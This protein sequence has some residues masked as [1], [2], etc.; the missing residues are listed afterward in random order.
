DAVFAGVK[1][2]KWNPGKEYTI[3]TF[4]ID[5]EEDFKL[6]ADTK[7]TLMKK[8][9]RRN[10]EQGWHF[11]TGKEKAIRTLA[12][13]VGFNYEKIEATGEYA[14]SA[15]IMFLSPDGVITRYLYGISFNENNIR[16]AL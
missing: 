2:V 9:N 5:P 12:E 1:E 15:A 4:S 11:L 3:I 7:E 8:L 10:A 14:H 13:A 6:A 16:N